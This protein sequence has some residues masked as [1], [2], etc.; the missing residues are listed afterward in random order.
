MKSSFLVCVAVCFCILLLD[1]LTVCVCPCVLTC[2][3]FPG[4]SAAVQSFKSRDPLINADAATEARQPLG[5]RSPRYYRH[6]QVAGHCAALWKA[7]QRC[8]QPLPPPPPSLTCPPPR[9]P[10]LP[11]FFSSS[12]PNSS[13][14]RRR[15]KTPASTHL[16][17]QWHGSERIE[18]E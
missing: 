10:L 6:T 5:Q 17:T 3:H 1:D 16:S 14:R 18:T 7:S 11:P 8:H 2:I 9:V 13:Q 15:K 4:G 12:N